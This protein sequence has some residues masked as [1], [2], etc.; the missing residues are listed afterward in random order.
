MAVKFDVDEDDQGGEDAV[1]Q[2]W[3]DDLRMDGAF[4]EA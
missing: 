4:D 1:Q 3:H 2:D